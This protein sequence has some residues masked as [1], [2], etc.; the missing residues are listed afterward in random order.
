MADDGKIDE[1]KA[2]ELIDDIKKARPNFFDSRKGAG[3][4]SHGGGRDTSGVEQQ[5]LLKMASA[6]NQQRIR[7]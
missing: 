3:T 1:K 2:G 5:E 6:R 4:G 7:G